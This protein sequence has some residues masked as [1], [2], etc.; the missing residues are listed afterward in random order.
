MSPNK[1]YAP[2]SP[3]KIYTLRPGSLRCHRVLGPARQRCPAPGQAG[4]WFC[5]ARAGAP[6]R[7][8]LAVKTRPAKTSCKFNVGR[9]AVAVSFALKKTLFY[10]LIISPFLSEARNTKPADAWVKSKYELYFE[11]TDKIVHDFLNRRKRFGLPESVATKKSD[12]AVAKEFRSWV[13]GN[14]SEI[15]FQ[16]ERLIAL[17]YYYVDS[18]GGNDLVK[19]PAI[20]IDQ[21]DEWVEFNPEVIEDNLLLTARSF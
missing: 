2:T 14:K 5:R 9:H 18:L 16:D 21:N 4:A 10:I 3:N 6:G 17:I 8:W 11:D 15:L 1:A 20:L 7:F 19:K 13:K 12:A